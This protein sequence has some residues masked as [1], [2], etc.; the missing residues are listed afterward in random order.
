M[1]I[2]SLDDQVLTEMSKLV[3][4]VVILDAAATRDV[5]LQYQ[6]PMITIIVPH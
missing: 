3:R 5:K 1:G 4:S 6:R 2:L